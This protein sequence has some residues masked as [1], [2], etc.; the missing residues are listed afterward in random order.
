MRIKYI[1]DYYEIRKAIVKGFT[2]NDRFKAND[3]VKTERKRRILSINKTKPY[4]H[5]FEVNNKCLCDCRC[6]EER[7]NV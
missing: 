1:N 5:Y 7:K 3:F 2:R 6:L 4:C